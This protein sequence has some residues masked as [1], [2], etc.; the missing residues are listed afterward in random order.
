MSLKDIIMKLSHIQIPILEHLLPHTRQLRVD[1][2]TPFQQSQLKLILLPVGVR[3]VPAASSPPDKAKTHSIDKPILLETDHKPVALPLRLHEGHLGEVI[4]HH[5]CMSTSNQEID[6]R[7]FKGSIENCKVSLLAFIHHVSSAEFSIND[8]LSDVVEQDR[9]TIQIP[10]APIW[11]KDEKSFSPVYAFHQ[12]MFI[13][14]GRQQSIAV[15]EDVVSMQEVI[16]VGSNGR[17][18]V[19]VEQDAFPLLFEGTDAA[20]VHRVSVVAVVERGGRLCSR[21]TR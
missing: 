4:T 15:E 21:G 14:D 5:L 10:L 18:A 2:V 9:L 12:F 16:V 8:R 19:V 7:Q 17:Y 13:V 6:F 20:H 11:Q 3:I 1:V